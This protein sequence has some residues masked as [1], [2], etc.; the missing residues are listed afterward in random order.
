MRKKTDDAAELPAGAE[1]LE[2]ATAPQDPTIEEHA[3]ALKTPAWALAGLKRLRRWGDGKRVTRAEFEGGLQV[4][5]DGPM[6][7]RR[8][9]RG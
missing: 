3:A 6:D 8:A 7:Q 1:T 5:L 2:T 9:A 4:F